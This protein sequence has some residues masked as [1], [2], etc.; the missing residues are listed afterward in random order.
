MRMV[1]LCGHCQGKLA[2]DSSHAGDP[3]KCPRCQAVVE[4]PTPEDPGY[5]FVVD[6][7]PEPA[8]PPRPRDR[9]PEPR[10]KSSPRLVRDRPIRRRRSEPG[11]ATKAALLALLGVVV[12]GIVVVL[13]VFNFSGAKLDP[14]K[15][16]VAQGG[17]LLP[18]GGNLLPGAK[19]AVL[20]AGWNEVIVGRGRVGVPPRTILE[21]PMVH[22][23]VSTRMMQVDDILVVLIHQPNAPGDD[24]PMLSKMA[25]LGPG[26]E[27]KSISEHPTRVSG[28]A[29]REFRQSFGSDNPRDPD[30]GRLKHTVTR[31]VQAGS[32][33]CAVS[34]TGDSK[35][36]TESAVFRTIL[37]SFEV[38]R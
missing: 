25:R 16:G 34:V 27:T 14:K 8:P 24:E 2:A 31:W 6:P 18:F 17:G 22:F 1:F 21:P 26:G 32:D 11:N 35:E 28:Y 9:E 23:G 19:P 3:V 36:A 15:G 7:E 37:D 29:A 30:F 5:E 20:P 12:V 10:R 33:V 38:L 13:A 4:C